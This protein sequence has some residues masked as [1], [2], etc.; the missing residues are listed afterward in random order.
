[1]LGERSGL[2][3]NYIRQVERDEKNLTINSL[4]KIASGLQVTLEQLFQS[5]SHW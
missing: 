2:Q 1:M 4:V 3:M 5:I